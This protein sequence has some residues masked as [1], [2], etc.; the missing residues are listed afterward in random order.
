M[1]LDEG[2][3]IE[4][5]YKSGSWEQHLVKSKLFV[6]EFLAN[7]GKVGSILILGA[8]RLYDCDLEVLANFTE[9]IILL[10]AD[11]RAKNAWPKS[12][13]GIPVHALCQDVTGVFKRWKCGDYSVPKEPN[14]PRADIIISLNLKSQLSVLFREYIGSK[15]IELETKL[16]K[17]HA[18]DVFRMASKGAVFIYDDSYKYLKDGLAIETESL[19][20][21][22]IEV[23]PDW[24][25][26][27]SRE[28]DWELEKE[29]IIHKVLGMGYTK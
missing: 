19:D 11:P 22:P 3:G 21:S 8:G 7:L 29:K 28:W 18:E 20:L 4:A 23:P 13:K 17:Q 5:R 27:M 24:K 10:D 12:V 1:F 2:F 15:K 6:A 25:E 16:Q 14:F 9:K 26:V